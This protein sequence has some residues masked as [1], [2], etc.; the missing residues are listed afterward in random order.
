M[1]KAK[2]PTVQHET[3]DYV[4]LTI[5][6]GNETAELAF[7][8]PGNVVLRVTIPLHGLVLLQNESIRKNAKE[9]HRVPRESR[10][11]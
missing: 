4:A 7:A 3:A 5:H 11:L 10:K 1:P 8:K 6:Q 9:Q 2:P